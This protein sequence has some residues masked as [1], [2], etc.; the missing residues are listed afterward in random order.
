MLLHI[1]LL[2]K[3]HY[4]WLVGQQLLVCPIGPYPHYSEMPS[5][6]SHWEF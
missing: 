3:H 5:K 1:L 2:V 4:V 6:M